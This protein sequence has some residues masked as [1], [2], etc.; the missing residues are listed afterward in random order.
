MSILFTTGATVTFRAL[1]DEITSPSFLEFLTKTGFSTVSLQYGNE[2]DASTGANISKEYFSQLLADRHVIEHFDFE[3]A[4]ETND[5]SITVFRNAQLTFQVFSFSHDI[6]AFISSADLVVSHAGTGSIL[7]TLR[8]H[9][10]L[11]VVTNDALMDGHQAEIAARFEIEHFLLKV[12]GNQLKEGVLQK[13]ISL[14][15]SGQVHLNTLPDP[16]AGVLQHVIA[17]ELAGTEY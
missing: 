16:P 1:V 3:L 14:W 8:L 10:P 4:N 7:D 11:I 12:D 17:G 9:K 15:K 13:K 5:K 6:G 2:T